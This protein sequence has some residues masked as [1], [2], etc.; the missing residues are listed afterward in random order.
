MAIVNFP[1]NPTIGDQYNENGI[2]YTWNGAAWT[3]NGAE[4]TDARYVQVT[5]DTMTGDLTVPS[6]NSGPLAGFRNHL[7]NSDFRVWQRGASF[8][9]KTIG[10]YTAD[11]WYAQTDTI[12]GN[13]GDDFR[14]VTQEAG[15]VLPGLPFAFRVNGSSQCVIHQAVELSYGNSPFTNGTTWTLSWWEAGSAVDYAGIAFASDAQNNTP[16]NPVTGA[17]GTF[18]ALAGAATVQTIGSWTRKASTFT[19]GADGPTINKPCLTLV[20]GDTASSSLYITGL[21]LEPGPVASPV[22]ARPIQTEL[23]LCQRYAYRIESSSSTVYTRFGGGVANGTSSLTALVQ[24]PVS[25]RSIPHSITSASSGNFQASNGVVGQIG[26]NLTLQTSTRSKT[27]SIII[28]AVGGGLTS[29]NY[30]FLEAANN[31]NAWIVFDAE[32]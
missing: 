9:G 16:F 8:A 20:I 28:L 17:A 29:G 1:A 26:T 14:R 30:Y 13:N 4:N 21:Q 7:I 25:M 2:T 27:S 6:L 3:A 19:V 15:N 5:G 12:T 23:A 32:L 10:Q 31:A 11:R 22:E 18:D 24:F